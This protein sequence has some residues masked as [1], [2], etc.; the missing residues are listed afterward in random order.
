MGPTSLVINLGRVHRW[1]VVGDTHI[2]YILNIGNEHQ[3]NPIRAMVCLQPNNSKMTLR[4]I[5]WYPPPHLMLLSW[6]ATLI[7]VDNIMIAVIIGSY[8]SLLDSTA[9]RETIVTSLLS[10]VEQYSR[11]QCTLFNNNT[12]HIYTILGRRCINAIQMF[13]VCWEDTTLYNIIIY[14]GGRNWVQALLIF[15]DPT[16]IALIWPVKSFYSLAMMSIKNWQKYIL[17]DYFT[18]YT[19]NNYATKLITF[20]S[21][22]LD[23]EFTYG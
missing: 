15:E 21:T 13:C 4:P 2:S 1:K 18:L 12:P 8:Q 5:S 10:D 23:I 14:M 7:N 22:S 19:L 17:H 11:A 3:R 9:G 16:E 20:I 6:Q